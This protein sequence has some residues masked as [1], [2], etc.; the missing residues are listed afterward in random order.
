MLRENRRQGLEQEL[1]PQNYAARWPWTHIYSCSGCVCETL[2]E[3]HICCT[4]LTQQVSNAS[5]CPETVANRAG[6][7]EITPRPAREK[8]KQ[9][10]KKGSSS[11]WPCSS[12]FFGPVFGVQ[13]IQNPQYSLRISVH[14]I[15]GYTNQRQQNQMGRISNPCSRRRLHLPKTISHLPPITM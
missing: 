4:M 14:N 9:T 8:N 11:S 13:A 12:C 2:H 6:N 15:C 3:Q 1:Q 7:P 5:A 10:K